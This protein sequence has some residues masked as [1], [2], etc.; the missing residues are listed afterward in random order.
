MKK[1]YILTFLIP[2][3]LAA[4]IAY[5]MTPSPQKSFMT[6]LSSFEKKD[7]IY[8]EVEVS[9]PQEGRSASQKIEQYKSGGKYYA[10]Y[11]QNEFVPV[12]VNLS[13]SD[14]KF[15]TE[16]VSSSVSVQKLLE[17][18]NVFMM[19]KLSLAEV[20]KDSIRRDKEA[21]ADKYFATLN[22]G[23]EVEVYFD[24]NGNL[25]KVEY[26]NIL[27]T[28]SIMNMGSKSGD[29]SINIVGLRDVTEVARDFIVSAKTIN[30]PLEELQSAI[31]NNNFEYDGGEEV[32]AKLKQVFNIKE[33]EF[34]PEDEF[35]EEENPAPEIEEPVEGAVNHEGED[36]H[37]VEETEEPQIDLESLNDHDQS[38]A[39]PEMPPDFE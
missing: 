18:N 5:I 12:I 10:K 3:I 27:Y 11:Y 7:N 37:G 6:K 33:E 26:K 36:F 21:N 1:R 14:V 9:Y 2:V 30:V 20:K 8:Y 16:D 13:G 31:V 34:L 23:T 38:G 35:T 4:L 28:P 19:D 24:K 39:E 29:V 17:E 22:N 25:N 32:F 15:G